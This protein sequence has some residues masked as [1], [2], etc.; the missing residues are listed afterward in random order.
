[1]SP[2]ASSVLAVLIFSTI[3]RAQVAHQPRV[4]VTSPTEVQSL[5]RPD[6]RPIPVEKLY[7][8][9]STA[10]PAWA[11]DG[12]QLVF[13]TNISGRLNIWT[14][15]AASGW[16]RQLTVSNERQM[17][18]SWSPDGAWIAYASDYGGNEQWDLFLVSP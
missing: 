3:T 10:T 17:E 2:R 7:T 18:P 15:R 6:A 8:T 16:P 14:V 13:A 4:Q 9:R 1:M 12:K 11:P 5:E